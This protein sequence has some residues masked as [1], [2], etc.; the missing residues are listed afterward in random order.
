MITQLADK[1]IDQSIISLLSTHTLLPNY[2]VLIEQEINGS[3]KMSCR[4]LL[5]K[6]LFVLSFFL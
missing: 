6:T 3:A 5:S 1:S 2:I 4:S